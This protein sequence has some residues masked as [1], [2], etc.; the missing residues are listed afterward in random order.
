MLS[1]IFLK[2]LSLLLQIWG[3]LVGKFWKLEQVNR[4]TLHFRM[5]INMHFFMIGGLKVICRPSPFFKTSEL[6]IWS[7]CLRIYWFSIVISLTVILFTSCNSNSFLEKNFKA[8]IKYC[9]L[10]WFQLWQGVIRSYC[11]DH[12]SKKSIE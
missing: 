7:L 3:S 4:E 1:F 5:I 9:H 11:A 2:P 8:F 12:F 6:Q 10:H